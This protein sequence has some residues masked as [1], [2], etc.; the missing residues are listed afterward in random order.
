MA[1][2]VAGVVKLAFQELAQTC[3]AGAIRLRPASRHGP[4]RP[5]S[6]QSRRQHQLNT[7]TPGGRGRRQ[8]PFSAHCART[9]RRA[10]PRRPVVPVAWLSVARRNTRIALG[11]VRNG[12]TRT[13]SRGRVPSPG[14][15]GSCIFPTHSVF[16]PP[17]QLRKAAAKARARSRWGVSIPSSGFPWAPAVSIGAWAFLVGEV[18]IVRHARQPPSSTRWAVASNSWNLSARTQPSDTQLVRHYRTRAAGGRFDSAH[19]PEFDDLASRHEDPASS[20]SPLVAKSGGRL[21]QLVVLAREMPTSPAR[22]GATWPHS[23][24]PALSAA[25]HDVASTMS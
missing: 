5:P 12:G 21:P 19:Y 14:C 17:P 3:I 11:T 4:A 7:A 22:R 6:A 16:A 24:A 25:R 9:R 20:S 8:K 18:F 10:S 2:L 1:C 23:T 13:L 15:A